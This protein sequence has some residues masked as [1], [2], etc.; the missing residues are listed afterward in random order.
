MS[1]SADPVQYS[2]TFT[3]RVGGRLYAQFRT[4]GN[5]DPVYQDLGNDRRYYTIDLYLESPIKN[6]IDLVEYD[7][8]HWSFNDPV[9]YS[10]DPESNFHEVVSSYGDVEVIVKVHTAGRVFVQRARLSDL[11]MSGH[12]DHTKDSILDALTRIKAN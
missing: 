8:N 3:K 2:T 7:M 9:G 1:Q 6:E 10:D 4:K 5:G 11:L 12:G